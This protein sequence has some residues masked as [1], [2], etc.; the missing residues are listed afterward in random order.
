MIELKS[1]KTHCRNAELWTTI[2]GI[3]EVLELLD[4]TNNPILSKILADLKSA[5]NP[6][7]D[8][9]GMVR[10]NSN[11][12]NL[13]DQDNLTDR[14]FKGLVHG[15]KAL[16]YNPS[17]EIAAKAEKLDAIIAAEGKTM[18]RESYPSQIAK[19]QSL[20]NKLSLPEYQTLIL[21]LNLTIITQAFFDSLKKFKELY[22]ASISEQSIIS[23]AKSAS[24]Y[25][26]QLLTIVN[27]Q[28]FSYMNYMVT[29]DTFDNAVI[30]INE[31]IDRVNQN[32]KSRQTRKENITAEQN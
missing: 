2:S 31:H 8:A 9:I 7:G 20:T 1:I 4:L 16:T 15:V 6:F 30:T 12:T 21:D 3:I 22:N 17:E 5:N 23:N 11:T 19:M 24:E 29:D 25:R 14:A 28:L 13:L 32:I 18:Y 26:S 27:K 10:A